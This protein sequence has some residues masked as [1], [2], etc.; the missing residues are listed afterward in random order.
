MLIY[1]HIDIYICVC[2]YVFVATFQVRHRGNCKNVAPEGLHL[3]Q[4]KMCKLTKDL[5]TRK[6]ICICTYGTVNVIQLL[7]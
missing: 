1:E 3:Q 2:L 4:R 5:Y 7:C 6:Y